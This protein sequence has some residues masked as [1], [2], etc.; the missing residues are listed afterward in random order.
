MNDLQATGEVRH[1]GVSNFSVDR[2]ETARDASETPI[3]TNH[4]EYNPSTD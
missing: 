1:I 4:I 2:L 3:V